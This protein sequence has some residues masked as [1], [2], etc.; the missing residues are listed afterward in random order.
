MSSVLQLFSLKDSVGGVGIPMEVLELPSKADKIV[1]FQWEPRVSY[2][3]KMLAFHQALQLL[4]RCTAVCKIR[5]LY[6]VSDCCLHRTNV[7][8]PLQKLGDVRHGCD[9]DLCQSSDCVHV[10]M[11]SSLPSGILPSALQRQTDPCDT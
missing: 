4:T 6:L 9:D 7:L 5:P 8:G 11:C 10:F 2:T 3:D 1:D